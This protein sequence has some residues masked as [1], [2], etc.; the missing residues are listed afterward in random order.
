MES[1]VVPAFK[2]LILI[3]GI[4][5][6]AGLITGLISALLQATFQVQE[7]TLGSVPRMLVILLVCAV[8]MEVALNELSQFTLVIFREVSAI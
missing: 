4:P 7:Q 6:L 2:L 3:S 1:L 8:F 5:L